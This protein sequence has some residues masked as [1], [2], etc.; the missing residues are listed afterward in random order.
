MMADAKFLE[1]D[2]KFLEAV[3]NIYLYIKTL[4]EQKNNTL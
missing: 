3:K 2:I 4:D 1:G